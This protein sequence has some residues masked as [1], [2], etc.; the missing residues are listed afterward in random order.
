MAA[1][2][3]VLEG[4]FS[5]H[6]VVISVDGD[7]VLDAADV[8]TDPETGLAASV[9]VDSGPRCRVQV[10]LPDHGRAEEVTLSLSD[11]TYLRVSLRDGNRPVL[12]PSREGPRHV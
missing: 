3:V 5:G 8:T 7:A 9:A 1:V 12:T 10:R 2:V 11:L 4:G 6:R